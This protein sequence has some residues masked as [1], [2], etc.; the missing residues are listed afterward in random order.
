[1]E[2][3]E[4]DFFKELFTV[5]ELRE[6]GRMAGVDELF[7]WRSPSAREYRPERR[8]LS[9]EELLNLMA[10]EPRLIRRPVT[11]RAGQIVLGFDPDGLS[12]LLE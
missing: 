4:R 11:V 5:E 3:R 9:D 6:L 12:A 7:S 10:G 8:K 1:M 2:I